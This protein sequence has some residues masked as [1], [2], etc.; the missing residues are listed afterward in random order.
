M[1]AIS[2]AFFTAIQSLTVKG[3]HVSTQMCLAIIYAVKETQECGDG[4]L[5]LYS[6]H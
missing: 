6:L 3:L 5:A 2:L 4:A 1:C